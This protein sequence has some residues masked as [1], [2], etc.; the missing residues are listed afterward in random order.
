MT[1]KP[2]V[3]VDNVVAARIIERILADRVQV[4]GATT[5]SAAMMLATTILFREDWTPAVLL[6]DADSLEE[7]AITEEQLEIGNYLSWGSG[8][9]PHK[10]VLA[11]P[12]VEAVL[13]S[14]RA[15]LENAL[16]KKIKDDDFFEARFRPKAVFQRL[17]GKKNPQERALAVIDR[18]D[19]TSLRRMAAHPVIREIREFIDNLERGKTGRA[20][21]VRRAS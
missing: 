4:E 10:L 3:V 8:G 1:R 9:H 2:C 14:D 21:K 18:I 19:E 15:G 12:Q 13:F 17:L 16:G 6:L 5:R 11:V 7:R 20:A